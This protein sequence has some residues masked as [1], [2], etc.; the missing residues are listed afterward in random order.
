MKLGIMQP[1]LFP[2]IGYFQLIN[3]VDTFVFYDDVNFIKR[4]WINRN[5]ILIHGKAYLFSIP[6]IKASQ[7]KLINETNISYETDWRT[8]FL[9]SIQTNYKAA[10]YF[11]EIYELVEEVLNYKIQSISDLTTKSII[12]CGEYIGINTE[13]EL[14][15]IEYPSTRGLDKADRL[16]EISKKNNASYYINPCGGKD[17]YNKDYFSSKGVKLK[18]ISNTITEYPQLNK[19]FVG[20]LSIIDVLMFNS[21]EDTLRLLN[22]FELV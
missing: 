15:S 7:N 11:S 10:K 4:G 2:Y 9:N 16:I 5:N 12:K 13:F 21:K 20:G 19:D 17:L 8:K 3:A 18:F 22:Q 14:S 1:Y 6:L